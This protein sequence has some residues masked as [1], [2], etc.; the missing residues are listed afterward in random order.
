M[1]V[2]KRIAIFCLAA[3]AAIGIG[4]IAAFAYPAPW[5][6][7]ASPPPSSVVL[8]V[9]SAA[10]APTTVPTVAPA[11]AAPTVDTTMPESSVEPDGGVEPESAVETDKND[12]NE[13]GDK[14][15]PADDGNQENHGKGNSQD[16]QG[17]DD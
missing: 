9:A 7:D 6:G 10:S 13:Q 5:T 1:A 14:A 8:R 4:V 3:C 12:E 17:H 2:Q 16:G 11:S 15:T